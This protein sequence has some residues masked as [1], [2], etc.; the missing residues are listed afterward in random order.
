MDF[1]LDL[2]GD[3]VVGRTIGSGTTGKVKLGSHKDTGEQVAIKVI[4]KS[5]F[6]A[7]P[8]VQTRVQREIAV[9]R[10]MNHPSLL[11][12]IEVRE[13]PHHLYMILEYAPH[14]ELFDYLVSRRH[15]DEPVATG[16]FR[17]IVYGL[18]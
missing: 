8:R 14:G 4:K 13:S 16:L 5:L 6:D 11:K 1:G 9:M 18:E 12:L 10:L 17:Q 2:V 7:K 3:Y 15:L